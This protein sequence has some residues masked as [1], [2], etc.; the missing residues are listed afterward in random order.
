M[1][2]VEFKNS[3]SKICKVSDIKQALITQI[4][5]KN[6]NLQDLRFDL[7][8][9][10]Y[11][12]NVIENELNAHSKE[13][14]IKIIVDIVSSLY[15]LSDPEKSIISNQI[16]YLIDNKKIKKVGK[17]KYV[18]KSVTNWLTKKFS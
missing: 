4:Q 6:L 2:I 14:K 7:E 1:E 13:E 17:V 10:T 15:L 12:C 18:Y 9:T 11:I 16:T 3:L 8:L 5:S